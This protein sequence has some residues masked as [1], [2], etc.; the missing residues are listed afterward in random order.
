MGRA[1]CSL[2]LNKTYLLKNLRLKATKTDRYLNTAK[3]EKSTFSKTQPFEYPLVKVDRSLS[4]VTSTTWTAKILGIQQIAKQASCVSCG[5]SVKQLPNGILG[6]CT[7]K[8][9]K[10]NQ[11]LSSC[12]AQWYLKVLVQNMNKPDEKQRLSLYHSDVKQ[13]V[14]ALKIH[15]DLNSASEDEITLQILQLGQNISV[16]FDSLSYK[17]T[18]IE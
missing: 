6:E 10:M 7:S 9:C 12:P 2:E 13:P 17:V 15:L 11:V 3:T 16:T 4:V 14:E 1:R 8:S 18:N 5:K